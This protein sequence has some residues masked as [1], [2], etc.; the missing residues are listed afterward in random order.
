MIKGAGAQQTY[1]H[2]VTNAMGIEIANMAATMSSPRSLLTI[3]GGVTRGRSSPA[4]RI[5]RLIASSASTVTIWMIAY[6]AKRTPKAPEP[7]STLVANGVITIISSQI[8]FTL[9]TCALSLAT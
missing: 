5:S 1:A 7:D 9:M 2:S 4:R 3:S 6:K 8:M